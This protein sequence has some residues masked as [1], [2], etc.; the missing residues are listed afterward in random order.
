MNP[1]NRASVLLALATLLAV[2]LAPRAAD[3]QPPSLPGVSTLENPVVGSY[4]DIYVVAGRVVDGVGGPVVGANL[5][6][7]VSQKNTR[8]T[9]LLAKTDCF[10]LFITYFDLKQVDPDGTVT[11]TVQHH[12]DA[13]DAKATANFDPFYRRSD[14]LVRYQ[15]RWDSTCPDQSPLFPARL[16]IQGRV[17]NRT[18]P[19]TRNGTTYDAVP[20]SGHAALR[21]TDEKGRVECATG[22][23][24]ENCSAVPIDER[25]DF[26]YSWVFGEPVNATGTMTVLIGDKSWNFTVDPLYRAAIAR[27]ELTGRGAPTYAAKPAPAPAFASAIAAAALAAIVLRRRP[28]A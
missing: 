23:D 28:G 21:W 26:I 24:Q 17:V 9:P 6:L 5:T 8:A 4:G 12:G 25:G 13:P 7:E 14:V 1:V 2:A 15:G 10:G 19:Y 27:V 18:D 3:A 22:P 20:Y 11:V 16:T